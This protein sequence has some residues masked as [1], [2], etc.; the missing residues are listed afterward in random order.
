MTPVTA[1]RECSVAAALDVIGEKWSLLVVRELILGTDKFNEIAANTGAPRDI[2]TARLRRLEELGVITREQY[3]KRPVRHAYV[4]TKKGRD[5]RPVVMALKH[6][7]DTHVM[8]RVMPPVLEH[9]CGEIFQPATHC[10]ACGEKAGGA[11]LTRVD[12]AS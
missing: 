1:P 8:G 3:S 5:L 9:S 7:G 4:L 12:I 11:S 2:L 6:W 10:A